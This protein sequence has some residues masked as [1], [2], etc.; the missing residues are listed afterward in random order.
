MTLPRNAALR[1]FAGAALLALAACQ[2]DGAG[3]TGFSFSGL[4]APEP[5]DPVRGEKHM[6]AVGHPLAARTAREILRKG[7]TAI[8]ATIAAEMVLTLVEPQSSGIGGGAFLMHFA[9]K[10]GAIDS[11]DGRETAPKSA[12]PYMFLDG[13]GKPLKW[14]DASVG[15]L[16]VGVPGL[17]RMLELAHKEHGRLPWRDL[18][19]PAIKLARDGFAISERLARQIASADRLAEGPVAAI[20]FFENDGSGKK[21][22]TILKNLDLADTLERVADNG[23]DAFY[24]G[25]IAK[26]ITAAVSRAPIRPAKM[27]EA[28]IE[29][30][31]AKKRPPVCL[32]YRVWL[33]CGMGP[34]SSGGLTTLQI[35]GILRAFDLNKFDI[36]SDGE[37]VQALH[38]LGEASRL[39]YADRNV[40][41]GDPDFVPVPSAGLLDPDYL[42]LRSG[43]IDPKK[44]LGKRQPGMPGPGATLR[45]AVPGGTDSLKGLSTTHLSIIDADG[46]AVSMTASIERTFGS[47]L[48]VRGFLLNNELTDFNFKPNAGG[49][50]VANRAEAGKRPR[51]SM[52][53]T[54]VF[55]GGGR[56]VMAIGSPGGSRIIGYVAKTLIAALDWKMNVQKAIDV[57]NVVNRNGPLEI[58][59]GSRFEALIP[60]LKKMGHE[61]RPLTYKS[62]LNGVMVTEDGLEGGSD[63]RR[64]GVALGD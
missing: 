57:P 17:L 31:K 21:A 45:P 1:L 54:L 6:V 51:S 43:E 27:T 15:G 5:G 25:D 36:E 64:E 41:I 19:Q 38:L 7:G 47:R 11:Y 8:D 12:T 40:Y 16:G 32:P 28:D 61:I 10:T 53:P 58:E 33:I 60:A 62:G 20:Y 23:A 42:T 44:A 46:N 35:L 52:S 50:P 39:A 4:T 26:A 14:A 29:A 48:M 9:A 22:G 30:Y 37:A 18:F 55:D 2:H 24:K 59:K 56:V 63:P 49:G 34:P 13:T 3:G